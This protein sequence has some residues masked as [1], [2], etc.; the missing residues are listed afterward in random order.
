LLP[1]QAFTFRWGVRGYE[2]TSDASDLWFASVDL[3][4]DPAGGLRHVNFNAGEIS[5]RAA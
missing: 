1:F 3:H 2:R 4:F 5:D